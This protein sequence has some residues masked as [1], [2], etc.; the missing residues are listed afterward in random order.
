LGAPLALAAVAVLILWALPSP[1]PIRFVL[2]VPCPSCGLTRA[3]RA[4]LSLDFAAATRAHPLWFIALPALGAF[5]AAEVGTYVV[6]GRALG[7]ERQRSV[8]AAFSVLIFALIAVWIA[9]F[10]GAFG[11]PVPV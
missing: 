3:A 5:V 10:F 11:G 1:C 9:R 6:R 8:R 2:G 4:A 7:L